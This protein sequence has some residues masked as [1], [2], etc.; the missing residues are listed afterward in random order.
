M[1]TRGEDRGWRCK[2]EEEEEKG[3][4]RLDFPSLTC[5]VAGGPP[6]CAASSGYRMPPCHLDSLQ[7]LRVKKE[8]WKERE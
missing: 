5:P 1:F 8:R 4:G 2:V 3:A 6:W 7:T